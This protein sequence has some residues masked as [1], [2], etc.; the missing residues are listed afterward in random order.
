M[1]SVMVIEDDKEIC[2]MIKDHLEKYNYEV[3]YT[4]TGSNAIDYVKE[5]S[6]DLIVLDLMLPFVSGDALLSEIRKF[7]DI[8]VI[9]VSAKSLTFN[10]IEL[11]RLGADDYL[12]KP[13]D[14]D[15]LLARIERN[16]QRCQKEA[17]TLQIVI[18][19]LFVDTASKTVMLSDSAI[20]LTAREYQILELLIRYPGKVFSK[21]NLYE[22]IW[23]EMFA[24]D[25]DVINTHISNLRKKLKDEGNRI[26]T[27]WGLGYRFV[28]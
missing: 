7:S 19:K 3:F 8:P 16:L 14:L 26:E 17:H 11:L 22:S 5:V 24:R 10:K 18:G 4:L 12:V 6:P 28:K 9:V 27:V 23:Q 13:F 25:N 21:Q 1:N 2:I 20:S 15:E